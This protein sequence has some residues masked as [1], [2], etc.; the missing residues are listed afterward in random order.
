MRADTEDPFMLTR[1]AVV[2]PQPGAGKLTRQFDATRITRQAHTSVIN[3]DRPP[4]APEVTVPG[5]S[6][7]VRAATPLL[8]LA[9]QLRGSHGVPDVISLRRQALQEIRRFED[10][11]AAH[12]VRN[13]VTLAARY[14]LCAGVDEAVLSTAWGQQSE[15][16]QQ[17]LLVTLHHETWA[18]EKFFDLLQRM[19]ANPAEH[20]D[21]LELQYLCLAFG[22]AGKYQVEDNGHSRLA[23]IQHDLF[24]TIRRRQESAS[25]ELS[26]R[27]R[28]IAHRRNPVVR[29]VPWWMAAAVAMVA[30]VIAFA[31]YYA[32]LTSAAAPVYAALEKVGT[33]RYVAPPAVP[34]ATVRLKQLLAG[35]EARGGLSV[36]SRGGRTIITLAAGLFPSGSATPGQQHRDILQ[37]VASALN[38]VPG[39][40][41]VV[42]HTDD[43]PLSSHRFHDN[44]ELS[45]ERAM[46]VA[47]LLEPGINGS[48]RLSWSGV[49]SADP[50][51]LPA[52]EPKNRARNR[53]VEIIH[54]GHS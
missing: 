25:A 13:E 31:G 11:A 23:A 50:R 12:G 24:G 8:L 16:V 22:F 38:Q 4:S 30:L 44:L 53:R 47:R 36:E 5:L 41:M 10:A 20:F 51:Y 54:I 15:W 49:G 28:G 17:T 26:P 43:Q 14:V 46:A 27:W 29:Y 37:R 9:A 35:D 39:R 7:L 48:T 1:T 45:R 21:L 19:S 3:A 40:V 52:S 18:G 2:R 33:E 32:R 6:P 34:P 42:G